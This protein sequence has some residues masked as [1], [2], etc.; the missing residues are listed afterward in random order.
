LD[1]LLTEEDLTAL[2]APPEVLFIEEAGTICVKAV[3]NFVNESHAV[4]S[5][6][7]EQMF[8]LLLECEFIHHLILDYALIELL[9]SGGGSQNQP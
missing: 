5:S 3:H 9:V 6:F 4:D 8:E 2:Q 1:F 7:C